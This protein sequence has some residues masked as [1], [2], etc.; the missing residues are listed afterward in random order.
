VADRFQNL[1]I[2]RSMSKNFGVPGLRLGFCYSRN[3]GMIEKLRRVVPTW[4]LNIVAEYF[5]SILPASVADYRES[6]R[7]IT[8]DVQNLHDGLADIPGLCAYPTGSNFV[9]FR[10]E[11]GMT[12]ADLQVRLLTEHLMYVRDCSNKIGLDDRHVRVASQGREADARLIEAMRDL[13]GSREA[14]AS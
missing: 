8:E 5:L 14:A 4:H 13:L 2:V 1:V 11:N 7:R 3:R 9:L 6:L 12:A 10:I